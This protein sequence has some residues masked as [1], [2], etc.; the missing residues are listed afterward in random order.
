MIELT[1][2]SKRYK[3]QVVLDQA[4]ASFTEPQKIYALIGPSGSGKSTLF[5]I[6]FGLD[7]D[8]QGHY[9]LLGHNAAELTKKQWAIIREQ[10]MRMVFQDYKLLE[11]LTVYDNLHLSGDY[12]DQQ[13]ETVL[14]TMKLTQFKTAIVAD[15]SGGQKQRLAIARAVIAKPKI[16]LL[17]EPTG[18][19]DQENIEMT[20]T[21]LD[22][23]RQQGIMILIITHDPQVAEFADVVYQLQDQQLILTKG[24]RPE[25][26]PD[27]V[28][29]EIISATPTT[30]PPAAK[31]HLFSYTWTNLRHTKRRLFCLAIPIIIIISA[32][33][34]SFT[35]FRAS[36]TLS[37]KN[38]FGGISERAITLNTQ[39]LN[40]KT[41]AR[42]RKE[43]IVSS[44]DGKRIGFSQADLTAARKLTGVASVTPFNPGGVNLYDSHQNTLK[45]TYLAAEFDPLI[46]RYQRLNNKLDEI[47][48]EFNMS[49][50]PQ[51]VIRDFNEAN[52]DLV[53]G[54]YPHDRSDEILI[55]DVLVLQKYHTTDLRQVL[56]KSITLNVR[57]N[58]QTKKHHYRIAGV[59]NTDYAHGLSAKYPIY[60]GY[61]AEDEK[62]VYLDKETYQFYRDLLTE[63]EAT[64]AV[65]QS[66]IASYTQYEQAVGTGYQ[67]MLIVAAHDTDVPQ[68]T[69]QLQTK[70]PA[71]KITSQ[72]DLR[73]GELGAIYQRLIWN[74]IG[75]SV[76]IAL[77]AG[78]LICFLNKS[79]IN[80]RS[81]E[82]AILYSLGYQRKDIFQVIA[83][84][85]G[86]LFGAYFLISC[87]ICALLNR[88]LLSK[89]SSARLFIYL[90]A[91]ENIGALFLL[92][93]MMLLIS[94]LWGISGVKQ[95]NLKYYLN[96]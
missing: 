39:D 73:H 10:E 53:A 71:Y 48:F 27:D 6:L 29:R 64:A 16:L 70:Y 2:L 95:K 5:N 51:R 7:N 61:A 35:A 21:Y 23:L 31:K 25:E 19:L 24:S 40:R 78:V 46:Q 47:T 91:P 32:F 66:L 9:Q 94:I 88:F 69:K 4:N 44:F 13:I 65:S 57:K 77:I 38:S 67:G 3:Q 59:Y 18:N 60:V 58:R 41:H 87:G 33:I 11:N 68:L 37:F 1:G 62:T 55:P 42:Y 74:L 84:E 72:E 14:A 26:A 90:F 82:L 75:G 85:N 36:S 17:D 49:S 86:L 76:A 30:I 50:T 81:R 22:Q 52:I 96:H 89:L 79:Y 80:G 56:R 34:L 54:N 20:M 43:G 63:D 83:L 8:Y 45:L 12:S 28:S 15:L 93:V 92:V